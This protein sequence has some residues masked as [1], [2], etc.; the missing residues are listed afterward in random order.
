M[1]DQPN[2]QV[3]LAKVA[4]RAY[5]ETTG[6]KNFRGEPMPDWDDLGDTIQRA[7]ISAAGAVADHVR[8]GE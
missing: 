4:Y 3:A 1:T 7:W 8:S 6:F 2:D 5:G